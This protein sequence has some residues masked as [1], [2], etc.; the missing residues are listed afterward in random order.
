MAAV[1]PSTS[2]LSRSSTSS[3]LASE[4]RLS[5]A[6]QAKNPVSV[7]L[8]KVLSS[9]FD[10]NATKEA[11]KTLSDLYVTLK[12]EEH[13]E[14]SSLSSHED[15]E[16]E[17][18]EDMIRQPAVVALDEAVPGESAAQARRHMRKDMENKL[19]QGSEQFLEAF[20]DVDQKL[21]QLQQ[22][23]SAMR[24]SCDEAE[25]QLLLTTDSSKILLERAGSL[26]QERQDVENKKSVVTAF[27][28]RYTLTE[29]ENEAI[30]SR[31][32]PVGP[33]FFAAMDR[34][35]AIRDDCRILMSGEDGPMQ[36]GIDIMASTSSSLEQGYEKIVRWCSHEF[37]QKGRELHFEVTATMREAV[38]RLRK[39]PE[40]LTEVLSILSQTRQ[41]TL[42]SSFTTA[43][44]RGGPSGLPRPIELHAHDPLRYIGD[45][46]AWVHQAVAA[47]RELLETLFQAANHRRMV[48]SV[49]IFDGKSEEEDWIQ[50]LMDLCVEKLCM[51]LKVRVQQTIRSQE[52]SI[53][54][55]KIANLMQF[56]MLTMRRTIGNDALLS[57][58]LLQ[59]TDIAYS[60]FYESISMQGRLLSHVQLENN[61]VSLT[62]PLAIL[63]HIQILREIMNVYQSSLIEDDESGQAAGFEKILDIMVDPAIEMITRSNKEPLRL[64]TKWDQPIYALNCLCY[65]KTALESFSF[66]RE[67]EASINALIDERVSSLIEEHYVN[68]MVDA[69]IHQVAAI[70][71][72]RPTNEP[73]SRI[74]L[75]QPSELQVTLRSFSLWL[76]SPDVVQSPRLSQLTVQHL[77]AKIH[78]T[79]LE[80]MVRAYGLICEEVKRPENKYEAASTL[81]GSERPFGQIHLLRQILGITDEYGEVA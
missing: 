34:T 51:P 79:A 9:N 69:H 22:H 61:D 40:L 1:K 39:R 50:E 4:S 36:A 27:L 23:I 44:T 71:A 56:Y 15:V 68:I 58:T 19:R 28:A 75:M 43:L 37:R 17:G 64:G 63:D 70:C 53:I 77:H 2:I 80:R 38:K 20:G 31:D 3:S 65:I 24:L 78:Q 67:K 41:T 8:Y 47:E 35:E 29:Q 13:N 18:H 33:I 11:L 72:N 62:P 52:S 60:V 10:D 6:P 14:K 30:I 59:V 26:R 21:D 48:G 25:N 32:E 42:M 16:N 45:I 66:T 46:F 12:A 76:S 73:L 7:R 54:S 55:Y 49:R 57:K 81:L 74:P 5:T